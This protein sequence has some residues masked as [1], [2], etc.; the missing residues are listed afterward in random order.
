MPFRIYNT[1]SKITEE[2]SPQK[3]GEVSVYTCGPTVYSTAHIGN[4]RTFLNADFL[5]RCLKEVGG[6]KVNWVLNITDIDDKT[7][8]RSSDPIYWKEKMGEISDDPKEN[9]RN[10]T[11]FYEKVFFKDFE[12]L[13]IDPATIKA[14]P[15][16]T[17]YINQMAE[18]VKL[19]TENGFAYQSEGSV[20]FDITSWEKADSYGKLKKLDKSTM[21]SGDSND[22][23]TEKKAKF[24]FVLWKAAKEGEPTW[25]LELEG[26]L[27]PGRPGWHLECSA[28]GHE[29][30][31]LPIDIHTGGIDLCFPHHED[32]LAQSKAGY[33]TD[34]VSIWMHNEFLDLDGEKMSKST[35]NIWNL[36]DLEAQ[37]ISPLAY[38]YAILTQHYKSKISF[39]LE[40][41]RASQKGM[42]RIQEYIYSLFER[43]EN[44]ES[45]NSQLETSESANVAEELSKLR[46][47]FDGFIKNDLNSP[48]AIAAV[49][50]F[51]GQH[52][53]KEIDFLSCNDAIAFF[54]HINRIYGVWEV[55]DRPK[56]ELPEPVV[57]LANQRLEAKKS[58]DWSK[59]DSL[60]EEISALG[61]TI[62]DTKD[63]FELIKS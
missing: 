18:L 35:G 19:I 24:D 34:P 60:R 1:A 9:L 16:A 42:E 28:M 4:F 30:L 12:R 38:R 56:E 52:S 61:Y 26:K 55:A 53:A 62:K 8:K 3:E 5:V 15:R 2:L 27:L 43:K 63:G 40:S 57:E 7:I 17:E 50:T 33:G 47:E 54:N 29:T 31:G 6:Y 10:F 46:E 41:C 20:Y 25:D 22:L 59:A 23:A 48:R 13:A 14:V 39:S 45:N 36:A 58:K 11:R 21:E 37:G 49:Y 32:E 51:I 44:L